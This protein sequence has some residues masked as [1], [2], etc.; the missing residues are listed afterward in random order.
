MCKANKQRKKAA[1]RK[2][3]KASSSERKHFADGLK[4]P[5]YSH[6]QP[7][8]H[9]LRIGASKKK[10]GWWTKKSRAGTYNTDAA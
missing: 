9:W 5:K 1:A 4:S 2:A 3:A 8:P 10:H 7:A 6:E